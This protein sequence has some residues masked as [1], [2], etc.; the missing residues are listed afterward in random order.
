MVTFNEAVN[1]AVQ[2]TLCALLIANDNVNALLSN[3]TRIPQAAYPTAAGLRRQLCSDD[4]D[5]DPS[6]IPPFTG[7][8]CSIG[9]FVN[10]QVT[11]YASDGSIDS[12]GP[13]QLAVNGPVG[14]LSFGSTGCGPIVGPLAP[15]AQGFCA[16][17]TAGGFTQLA[18]GNG[19]GGVKA[20]IT[21]VVP[22][23]AVPDN[24]GD[25]P[26]PPPN[27]RPVTPPPVDITYNIDGDTNITIPVGFVFSPFYI[28][29]NF[30]VKVPIEFNAGGI[31]FKGEATI[32]PEFNFEF[33]PKGI[34]AQ[35]GV[36]D[37]DPIGGGGGGGTSVPEDIPDADLIIGVLVFSTVDGTNSATVLDSEDGPNIYAPRIGNVQFAIKTGNSIGWTADQDVKNLEAYIPCPAPQGAIAV[38]VTPAP[39]FS[40]TFTPVRGRP[41]TET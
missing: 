36:P 14:G 13:F 11:N 29:P 3:I 15:E 41:L 34:D 33:S 5:N 24:C 12:Q 30:D 7:G 18:V 9:Y 20:S 27:P 38:R 32:S 19:N 23:A 40:R 39:G 26:P 35:P 8:Q 2:N 22:Q 25:P 6:Y 37:D 10:G 4:P 21:S 1:G 16:F 17:L 28:S 31:E